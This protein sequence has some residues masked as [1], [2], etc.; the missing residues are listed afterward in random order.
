MPGLRIVMDAPILD[1]HLARFKDLLG[2]DFE[3]YRGHC[4]RVLS[5][6]LHLLGGESVHRD[7]IEFAL[8]YH[9]IALWTDR[10]LAYLEPSI[11]QAFAALAAEGNPYPPRLIEDIIEWH[12]KL[13][14]FEG[15]NADVVNAVRRADW[16]DASKGT[17]KMGMATADVKAAVAAIPYAGFHDTLQRLAPELGGTTL[18]GLYRLI[19]RVYRW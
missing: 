18:S 17:I 13:T 19:S 8:A 2:D 16:I 14:P 6:A 1:R 10:E 4:R 12:H 9:D 15:P 11:T 5:Y 7:A 3:G